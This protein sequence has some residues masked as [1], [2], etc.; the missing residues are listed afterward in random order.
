MGFFGRGGWSGV[1]TTGLSKKESLLDAAIRKRGGLENVLRVKQGKID[2]LNQYDDT[3]ITFDDLEG[4][5]T[6]SDSGYFTTSDGISFGGRAP[7]IQDSPEHGAYAKE[8]SVRYS[9]KVHYAQLWGVDVEAVT[10]EHIYAM[11]RKADAK[12]NKLATEGQGTYNSEMGVMERS[13][14]GMEPQWYF[15]E[16]DARYNPEDTKLEGTTRDRISLYNP[17]TGTNLYHAMNTPEFNTKWFEDSPE[18]NK[19]RAAYESEHGAYYETFKAPFL[20]SNVYETGDG[21]YGV[22]SSDGQI[23]EKNLNENDLLKW[24]RNIEKQPNPLIADNWSTD[25]L[26]QEVKKGYVGLKSNLSRAIDPIPHTLDGVPK[27]TKDQFEAYRITQNNPQISDLISNTPELQEVIANAEKDVISQKEIDDY[28][29]Y[30]LDPTLAPKG[31]KESASFKRVNDW[32][33]KVLDRNLRDLISI[34]KYEEEASKLDTRRQ[35]V[36]AQ[37]SREIADNP[38]EDG[39]MLNSILYDIANRKKEF[40]ETIISSTPHMA[41]AMTPYVGIPTLTFLKQD[42]MAMAYAEKYKTSPSKEQVAWMWG[43]ALIASRLEKMGAELIVGKSKLLNRA[44]DAIYNKAAAKSTLLAKAISIPSRIGIS[45]IVESVSEMGTQAFEQM[46]ATDVRTDGIDIGSAFDLKEAGMAGLIGGGSLTAPVAV[47]SEALNTKMKRLDKIEKKLDIPETVEVDN[48]DT[49]IGRLQLDYDSTRARIDEISDMYPEERKALREERSTL[50][51]HLK[52]LRKKIKSKQEKKKTVP[53]PDSPSPKH[54]AE[55][56]KAADN[57]RVDLEDKLAVRSKKEQAKEIKRAEKTS[58]N[59]ARHLVTLQKSEQTEEVIAK[60]K[61]IKEQI[62]IL[63]VV[64]GDYSGVDVDISDVLQ[65]VKDIDAKF[66]K[67]DELTTEEIRDLI[68]QYS[69]ATSTIM[70]RFIKGEADLED[71]QQA[72]HR[73]VNKYTEFLG[74]REDLTEAQQIVDKNSTKDSYVYSLD[75]ID[76]SS[77]KSLNEILLEGSL[78]SQETEIVKAKQEVIESK[79]EISQAVKTVENVNK[80]ITTGGSKDFVSFNKHLE[81][82]KKGDNPWAANSGLEQFA[83]HMQ[84][85]A[86]ILRKAYDTFLKTHKVT[87]VEYRGTDYTIDNSTATLLSYVEKEAAYGQKVLILAKQVAEATVDREEAST[88]T[89]AKSKLSLNEKLLAKVARINTNA[90]GKETKRSV[91]P[92]TDTGSSNLNDK[93][94]NTGSGT[95]QTKSAKGSPKTTKSEKNTSTPVNY[96]K[97][98]EQITKLIKR[99]DALVKKAESLDAKVGDTGLFPGTLEIPTAEAAIELR[100]KH[101]KIQER[102]KR[103]AGRFDL[104]IKYASIMGDAHE[105]ILYELLDGA[106]ALGVLEVE[107]K[108]RAISSDYANHE[109][110]EDADTA[111]KVDITALKRLAELQKNNKE[112]QTKSKVTSTATPPAFQS[113]PNDPSL[114]KGSVEGDAKD[115]AMRKVA[116]SFI[117]ETSSEK[118]SS[119]THTSAESIAAKTGSKVKGSLVGYRIGTSGKFVFGATGGVTMLARNGALKGTALGSQTKQS[120]KTSADL[121][122]T[123]VV[124]DM[125]NV[126]SQFIDYLDEIGA[127]YTIY[128]TGETSRINRITQKPKTKAKPVVKKQ[129][130][131]PEETTE[132]NEGNQNKI[133]ELENEIEILEDIKPNTIKAENL[134]NKQIQEKKDQLKLLVPGRYAKQESSIPDISTVQLLESG[135]AYE[136]GGTAKVYAAGHYSK[137]QWI[138]IANKLG[139]LP[140]VC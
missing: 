113:V 85:K 5:G 97:V 20:H 124:G 138:E 136:Q 32:N 92:T 110:D 126:D 30:S 140:D 64:I 38:Y 88:V 114:R 55:L 134:L 99:G 63:Q 101:G 115:A 109:Y 11:G 66:E 128:H 62:D 69:D 28:K 103:L 107:T 133:S 77:E 117:G 112:K 65:L 102:F 1:G 24:Q 9:Q 17:E 21:T 34:M 105:T 25:R 73:N 13:T 100:K 48:T 58:R 89:S 49:D 75:H 119:S 72:T 53:N 130:E 14:D 84:G 46:G 44:F 96:E 76:E 3:R 10:D 80:D 122:S 15:P 8:S 45:G 6:D 41:V 129:A 16:A 82:V 40:L 57:L 127:K 94:G 56:Q 137:S 91:K 35:K 31:Y 139:V 98:S 33:V 60:I 4:K 29:Q 67:V 7:T 27:Y 26:S 23:N 2:Y 125:P 81:R 61:S 120:I 50:F 90:P 39:G 104:D 68:D 70:Q 111:D 12:F 79:R 87:V 106:I 54:R 135:A 83:K 47:V 108:I 78:S 51:K 93:L 36:N 86:D 74:Q 22:Y 123:F 59:L 121:G 42:D 52:A 19:I 131:T 71:I 37:T 116:D 118:L 18:Q 95:K 132:T 43:T